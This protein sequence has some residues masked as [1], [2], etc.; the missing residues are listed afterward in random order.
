VDR[1][2]QADRA[3]VGVH[4]RFDQD[5]VV[6]EV[7]RADATEAFVGRETQQPDRAGFRENLARNDAVG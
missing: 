1:E 7:A 4:E 3:A 5:L 2:T 6:A